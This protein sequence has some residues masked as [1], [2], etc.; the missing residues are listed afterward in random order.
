[1]VAPTIGAAAT[2]TS[3]PAAGAASPTAAAAPT[4]APTSAPAAAGPA[5]PADAAPAAQQVWVLN[6]GTLEAKVLDFY[7]AVYARPGVA[8]LFS[9]PLVRVDKDFQLVPGAALS[10]SGSTDGKTWT[11]KLDP[12]LIW[13]DGNPVTAADYV[14]TFQ[15]AADPKHAW[16]F[17]WFFQGIVVG[18][19]DAIA[20]K[21]P[22]DQLGVKQ[23]ADPQTLVFQTQ[24]AAP[25]LPAMLLYSWP[26]SK[27]ALEKSGPLYN[28]KPETAVSAG[29]FMLKEWTKDQRIVYVRN[30]KYKGKLTPAFTQIVQK[31]A[32]AKTDFAAFQNF[33]IDYTANLAPADIQVI[34]KDP[35]LS[36]QIYSSVGDFRTYYLFFDVTKAPFTDIKVRQAF[37]HVVDRDTIQKSILGP[38][39]TPAYSWLAP[40]FPA[41]NREGLQA[42]QAYDVAKGKQL[43]ADAGFPGGQGFPK[44]TMWLRNETALNQAVAQ[45]IAAQIKQ[46]LGIEV[47][48]SNKDTKAFMDSLTAKPTQILFGFVSY[49]MDFLDPFNMLSVWLSGGRHSWANKDFDDK[50]KAAASFLGPSDQRI[51]MFQDAERILVTD[52]PGVFVYHST[53]LQIFQPYIT[54]DALKA[55]NHGNASLHWPGYTTADTSINGLY[56]T[57]DVTK[58]KG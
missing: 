39:G 38:T 24:V 30:D 36:K 18:W 21:L 37:S 26:L 44:Q 33:E 47:E 42:I 35:Q 23:G 28:V 49:G 17:T 12:N 20:G 15:Y 41:S 25:Y 48:V 32:D 43:L 16:D 3:A 1:V 34:L 7:E 4:S 54:G 19:D 55:D 5:L 6:S 22:L 29:P 10:W 9:E 50:V 52:V 13:S 11:F 51:K 40:G 14:K 27:A 56:A 2:A 8:D 58:R 45:S 46:N 31:I 53:P 57:K